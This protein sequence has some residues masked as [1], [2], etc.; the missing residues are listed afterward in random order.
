MLRPLI[1]DHKIVASLRRKTALA[2]YA[3]GCVHHQTW[4]QAKT[5]AAGFG[6]EMTGA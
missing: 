4:W 6:E 3:D 1:P 2:C 5:G